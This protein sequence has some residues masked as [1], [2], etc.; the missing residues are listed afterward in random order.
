MFPSVDLPIVFVALCMYF[1]KC[2][3]VVELPLTHFAN[4]VDMPPWH[5]D[6]GCEMRGMTNDVEVEV[7]EQYLVGRCSLR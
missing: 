7:D 4:V 2:I 6:G 1:V 3:I 5:F